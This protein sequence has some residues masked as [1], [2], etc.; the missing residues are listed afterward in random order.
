MTLADQPEMSAGRRTF[1]FLTSLRAAVSTSANLTCSVHG[2]TLVVMR[3]RLRESPH[4]PS[5]T[6]PS[7]SD[8]VDTNT[9]ALPVS[10]WVALPSG[11]MS[12]M[13]CSGPDGKEDQS[14]AQK[15]SNSELGPEST[16]ASCA[17][18]GANDGPCDVEQVEIDTGPGHQGEA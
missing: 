16:E 2:L 1:I 8:T 7:G 10:T 14:G 18:R 3:R 4:S 9:Y 5:R 13:L 15:Q 6:T 12:S 17:D 11:A